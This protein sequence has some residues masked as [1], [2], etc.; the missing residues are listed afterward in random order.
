MV[1]AVVVPAVAMVAVMRPRPEPV[2]RRRQQ[3]ERAVVV[4]VAP[5]VT[6]PAPVVSF[7]L[8]LGRTRFVS[9]LRGFRRWCRRGRF[10]RAGR[11]GRGAGHD[12]R[13]EQGNCRE[14]TKP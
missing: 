12:R 4:T 10:S 5:V 13:A 2:A 9:G 14:P 7:L 11:R 8:G 1:P 3:E 6:A